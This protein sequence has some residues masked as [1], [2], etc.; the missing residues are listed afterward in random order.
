M[1]LHLSCEDSCLLDSLGGGISH[2][3]NSTEPPCHHPGQNSQNIP[4]PHEANVTCSNAQ[5]IEAKI[6]GCDEVLLQ[7]AVMPAAT[8]VLDATGAVIRFLMA[9]VPEFP[10][11][12]TVPISILR[13]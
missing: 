10:V 4:Q 3:M 8:S 6:Y 2:A 9:D 12:S 7:S 5:L 11:T 1:L 13:I